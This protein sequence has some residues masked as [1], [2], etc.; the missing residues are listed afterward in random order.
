[1]TKARKLPHATICNTAAPIST[2]IVANRYYGGLIGIGLR[3]GPRRMISIQWRRPSKRL[4]NR[5][6]ADVEPA[7]E[8]AWNQGVMH[9]LDRM[10]NGYDSVALSANPYSP[11]R[12]TGK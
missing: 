7:L 8:G 10:N 11:H 12:E 5:W 9:A 2:P 3:I 1:M 6:L 4:M